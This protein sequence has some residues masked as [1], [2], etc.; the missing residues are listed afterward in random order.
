M[1]ALVNFLVVPRSL[2]LYPS[3][4]FCS[5]AFEIRQ[6]I[7]LF[8]IFFVNHQYFSFSRKQPV[9]VCASFGSWGCP[10]LFCPK[11]ITFISVKNKGLSIRLP[12][13]LFLIILQ[14]C[15]RRSLLVWVLSFLLAISFMP[16][17]PIFA[18]VSI[19]LPLPLLLVSPSPLLFYFTFLVTIFDL[20]FFFLFF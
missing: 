5:V 19:R 20:S 8:H 7:G 16:P 17:L 15:R 11:Q 10:P 3:F 9:A 2:P 4:F 13:V 12:S 18:P 1:I 14:Y 6:F